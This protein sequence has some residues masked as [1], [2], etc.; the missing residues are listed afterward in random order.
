MNR[1]GIVPSPASPAKK[2]KTPSPITTTPAE[3]KK[4]GACFDFEKETELKERSAST[5]SVPRANVS[6]I[7]DPEIN[8]PLASDATCID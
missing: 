3:A 6:M 5:G 2:A 8:D 4:S 7:S 1:G